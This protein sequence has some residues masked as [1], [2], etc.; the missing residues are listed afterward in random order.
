MLNSSATVVPETT[1]VDRGMP[2]VFN[3]TFS[4]ATADAAALTG[5]LYYAVFDGLT[6]TATA[7]GFT[8]TRVAVAGALAAAGGT[9]TVTV[10]S[11]SLAWATA[12]TYTPVIYWFEDSA[13]TKLLAVAQSA[14]IAVVGYTATLAVSPSPPILYDPAYW[15]ITITRG[16]A[17]PVGGRQLT[18]ALFGG[19]GSDPGTADG[20]LAGAS[21]L[22]ADTTMAAG[23][24]T[25]TCLIRTIYTAIANRTAKVQVFAQ[26]ASVGLLGIN[27]PQSSTLFRVRAWVWVWDAPSCAP[28]GGQQQGWGG[29]LGVQ[30]GTWIGGHAWF[31]VSG[32]PLYLCTW[33]VHMLPFA[34]GLPGRTAIGG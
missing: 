21:T 10:G 8:A 12:G 9:S 15:N 32:P 29:Q 33:A 25:T 19:E 5:T 26:G 28:T 23:S 16:R 6:A 7:T 24:T 30:L 2:L 34:K 1:E 17:A 22:K 4:I 27:T 13:G 3:T 14:A 20:A 18:C 11:I 31:C